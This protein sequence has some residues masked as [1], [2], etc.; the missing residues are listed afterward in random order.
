MRQEADRVAHAF[1]RQSC[2]ERS[3]NVVGGD[4]SFQPDDHG[5]G[6]AAYVGLGEVES[7]VAGAEACQ[8]VAGGAV[9]GQ[10]RSVRAWQRGDLGGLFRLLEVRGRFAARG[11]GRTG[12]ALLG[13][14]VGGRA[15][16][17]PPRRQA[18]LGA[19]QIPVR[20]QLP[21][22]RG[23]PRLTLGELGRQDLDADE[24]SGRERLDVG[25]Q[26]DG[27]ERQIGMLGQM[28]SDDRELLVVAF[29]HVGNSEVGTGETGGTGARGRAK[30]LISHREVSFPG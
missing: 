16:N 20:L 5:R 18:L 14:V 13:L 25:R 6:E 19:G 4:A 7:R 9:G 11:G 21:Q 26:A 2:R 8:Y 28:V 29:V 27:R 30:V 1:R 23:D 3:L 10:I 24:R 12:R 22:G 15:G 17:D